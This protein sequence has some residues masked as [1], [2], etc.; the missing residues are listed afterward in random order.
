MDPHNYRKRL[1]LAIRRLDHFAISERNKELILKFKDDCMLELST[2]RTIRYVQ[3]LMRIAHWL[4]KDFESATKDDIKSIVAKVN[5]ENYSEWT[6]QFYKVT[7]RKFYS[8]LRSKE[9]PE[10]TAWIKTTVKKN[11]KKLPEDMLTEG[12]IEKL[13]NAAEH[14]RDKALIAVLYESGCRIGELLEMRIKHVY[15]DGYGARILLNGKTGP[16]RIRLVSSVPYLTEWI[17]K[18]PQKDNPEHYIWINRKKEQ[19]SYS[20]LSAILKEIAIKAGV[21]TYEINGK[22]RTKIHPHL[23]RHSRASYLANHLTEA[24]MNQYFGWVQGSNMPAIYIHISGRDVDPA[25]LR[26]YGIKNREEKRESKLKPKL[27]PRCEQTNPFT[28]KF[29]SRCGMPLDKETIIEV[30]E[31]D[32]KRKQMDNILDEMLQDQRFREM[33]MEKIKEVVG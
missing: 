9:A 24:Q 2:G 17:N 6:K 16:R 4:G 15:P 5:N 18:H 30:V 12:E 33:F 29:C 27:C 20:R 19:L 13:I 23:F 22:S 11:K 21:K 1:E 28:N 7:L 31:K 10:E 3:N 14:P 25:I 32:M 26:L 8:W